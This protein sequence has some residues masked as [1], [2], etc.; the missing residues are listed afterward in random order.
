[1]HALF[2]DLHVDHRNDKDDRKE[3]QRR[4]ACK[5]VILFRKHIIDHTDDGIERAF[6]AGGTHGIAEDTDDGA[7][8]LEAA[9][10]AGND[11]IGDHGRKQRHGDLREHAPA[12]RGINL[13]SFVVLLVDALQTAQKHQDLEGQRIPNDI[14]DQHEHVG[15]VTGAGIDPVDGIAAEEHD[16]VVD[17]AVGGYQTGNLEVAHHVEHGG[18]HHADGD[19]VGH[20]G[21]EEDG[22]QELLQGL[23]GVERHGD[24]Q[25]QERG[26]RHRDDRQ[27]GR[28]LQRGEEAVIAQNRLEV[29]NADGEGDNLLLVDGSEAVIVVQECQAN[30]IDD[31][32]HREHQQQYDRRGQIKPCFPLML[33]VYHI[34]SPQNGCGSRR[35][36]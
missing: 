14:E 11:H 23:D 32:P 4:S 28:V 25:R 2:A 16:D 19:G 31:G 20:I 26:E 35:P 17:Q 9:D 33:A 29:F 24:E 6:I 18:K 1:M 3:D 8:L 5:T 30:R 36:C 7:V 21:E 12:G 27:Q 10:K 34:T 22:L 13:R 15:P